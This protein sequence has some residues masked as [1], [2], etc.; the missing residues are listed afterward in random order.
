MKRLLAPNQ[1]TRKEEE[2][3]VN[4]TELIN[5]TARRLRGGK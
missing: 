1:S 5:E 2:D 4:I 3:E